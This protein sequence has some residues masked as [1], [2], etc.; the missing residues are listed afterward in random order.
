V[1][2]DKAETRV[3]LCF[4]A[5]I[6]G[7]AATEAAVPAVRVPRPRNIVRPDIGKVFHDAGLPWPSVKS[8][9]YA[10]AGPEGP[11]W[12]Y[13][14]LL[15]TLMPNVERLGLTT[16][17]VVEIES[18]TDRLSAEAEAKKPRASH[19]HLTTRMITPGRHHHEFYARPSAHQ[20][21]ISGPV[22]GGC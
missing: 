6:A 15:R 8:V 11:L 5:P 4:V 18:L 10:V 7:M 17:D 20:T 21:E 3:G 16:A 19:H 22:R 2:R 12:Y 14:D 1:S 9:Q 13:G